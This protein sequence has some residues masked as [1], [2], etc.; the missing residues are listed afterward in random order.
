[1]KQARGRPERPESQLSM[2]EEPRNPARSTAPRKVAKLA[3]LGEERKEEGMSRVAVHN[4][5]WIGEAV[6][7]I[8]A[9]AGQHVTFNAGQF[10][11]A[12][13]GPAPSHPNA[14]GVTWRHAVSLG[15]VERTGMYE[16]SPHPEAHSRLVPVYRSCVSGGRN[17]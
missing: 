13:R 6:R 10:M 11:V 15:I 9:F 16:K 1:M 2:F 14:W 17:V 8:R 5:G 7:E 4:D 12:Y 3:R